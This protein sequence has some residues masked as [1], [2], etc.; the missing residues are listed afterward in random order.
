[1]NTRLLLQIP[2]TF[3]GTGWAMSHLPAPYLLA[4]AFG[5][6]A[7]ASLRSVMPQNSQDRL[8]WWVHFREHRQGW[9]TRERHPRPEN[10]DL[11]R[12]EHSSR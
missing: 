7:L 10:A 8:T 1:M 5:L 9:R 4:L 2:A 3:G 6:L 12:T 11:T